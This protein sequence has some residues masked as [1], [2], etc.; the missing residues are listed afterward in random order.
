MKSACPYFD[1][2]DTSR[3]D[4]S[5]A[6]RPTI[7]INPHISS[8]LKITSATR[9]GSGGSCFA[10]NISAG[11]RTR[12]Y[13]YFVTEAAP[14]FM[15]EET[16]KENNYGIFSARYGNLYTP[17][18]WLQLMQRTIGLFSPE[19]Q[20]WHNGKGRYF[21]LLRPR[22]NPR[23]FASL[24]ELKADV[25]HHLRSVRT[26]FEKVEVFVFTLGLTEGWQSR[27]DGTVYPTC[28]GCG[29]A[30][31]FDWTSTCFAISTCPRQPSISLKR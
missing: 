21:D 28:P 15:S 8:C 2:P 10:Q 14:P 19:D 11:L 17:L 9:V 7:E 24:T 20:F 18:Q 5:M 26:L 31:E 23:G 22:I 6:S 13:Q 4:R 16:A 27:L 1:L 29:S 25:R 3:W 30:G 12:G